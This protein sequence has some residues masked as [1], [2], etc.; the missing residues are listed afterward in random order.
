VKPSASNV[1]VKKNFTI[2]DNIFAVLLIVPA[3]IVLGMVVALPVLKGIYVS[4][5]DYTISNLTAPV[6]N[7]FQNYLAIFEDGSILVY[8]KNTIVFVVWTVGIQFVLGVAIALLLN[9][10]IKGC[11]IFRGLFLIPW[12]IPSVVVAILFRWMLHQQFGVLN[13]LFYK[14]GLTN[15]INIAWTQMPNL[16]MAAVVM[17]SVWRQLPYM[18][19][20]TL[21]GLQSVDTSLIEAARIDGASGWKVLTHITLPAIRPVISTTIWIAILSNFQMFTIVFNMTGGGPVDATTTLGIGAYQAA[22][23]SFDFGKGSAIGVVWL[24]ALF[25]ATMFNNKVNEKYNADYQ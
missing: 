19:V 21:A 9:A 6:L 2:K 13:Y 23:Q 11:G 18:A 12:T 17:A 25:L 22:F 4:F 1:I 20:M 15:T 16:A 14:A 5:C 3:L 8:F 24:I 7:N 10:K